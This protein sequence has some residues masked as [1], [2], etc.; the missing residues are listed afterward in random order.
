MTSCLESVIPSV[1]ECSRLECVDCEL[2]DSPPIPR[3][4]WEPRRFRGAGRPTCGRGKLLRPLHLVSNFRPRAVAGIAQFDERVIAFV[5]RLFTS[6]Q[7][8]LGHDRL[9]LNE[10]ESLPLT[11]WRGEWEYRQL[12]G[13][14]PLQALRQCLRR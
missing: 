7:A 14:G 11:S 13:L 2:D 1:C 3:R 12:P 5:Q 10:S 6:A 4:E 9:E 8:E